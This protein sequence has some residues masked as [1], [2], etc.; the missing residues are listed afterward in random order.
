VVAISLVI[1]GGSGA[2]SGGAGASQLAVRPLP[3]YRGPNVTPGWLV[4]P[5]GRQID[6]TSTA[7]GWTITYD[8]NKVGDGSATPAAQAE[9]LQAFYVRAFSAQNVAYTVDSARLIRSIASQ[10]R[11]NVEIIGPGTDFQFRVVLTFR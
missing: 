5:N 7:T 11:V 2:P 3:G 1:I 8:V 4:P 6:A 9:M 10:P